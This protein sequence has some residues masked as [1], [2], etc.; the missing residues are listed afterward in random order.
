MGQEAEDVLVAKKVKRRRANW[1]VNVRI[2]CD[3]AKVLRILAPTLLALI[4]LRSGGAFH[5]LVSAPLEASAVTAS[6]Q[7]ARGLRD[8]ER[9][10]ELASWALIGN[11]RE[12]A[13]GC[14]QK[15]PSQLGG[16]VLAPFAR[17]RKRKPRGT[18]HAA[19]SSLLAAAF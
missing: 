14:A 13:A 2:T 5:R 9:A 11:Q 3:I 15:K 17:R 10:R 8:F 19:G 18:G 7:L 1:N 6:E 4:L 12:N 16:H